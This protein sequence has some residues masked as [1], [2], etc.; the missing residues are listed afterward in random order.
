M[1]QKWKV[2]DTDNDYYFEFALA[3]H[4]M[5]L[6]NELKRVDE[7]ADNDQEAIEWCIQEGHSTKI[8]PPEDDWAQTVPVDM[9]G[10]PFRGVEQVRH[11]DNHHMGLG[12]FKLIQ[13]VTRFS[14]ELSLATG[15]KIFLL[16][17]DGQKSYKDSRYPWQGVAISCR[18]NTRLIENDS[19]EPVD[20]DIMGIMDLLRSS[21]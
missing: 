9:I 6:L 11:S 16:A 21:S 19:Q 13:V 1:A 18:F 4:G 20:G 10:N 7:A 3:D 8:V 15:N 14:G 5:G 17:E 12:L 2:P